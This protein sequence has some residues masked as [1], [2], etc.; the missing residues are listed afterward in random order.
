MHSCL[1]LQIK[2]QETALLIGKHH[3]LTLINLLHA[4]F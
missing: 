2:D 3:L 1:I 4:S